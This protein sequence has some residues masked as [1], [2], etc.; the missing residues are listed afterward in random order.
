MAQVLFS[1]RKLP[2]KAY[3]KVARLRSEVG[4]TILVLRNFLQ[5]ILRNYPEIIGP[6]FSGSGKIKIP[7]KFPADSL[8]EIKKN[9]PMSLCRRA[10]RCLSGEDS[11]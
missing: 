4:T 1:L 5:K 10:E 3:L 8:Q 2:A 9:S 11:C 7:A 6:L